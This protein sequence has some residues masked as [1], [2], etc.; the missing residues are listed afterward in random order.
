MVK[1]M[2]KKS[3]REMVKKSER[4]QKNCAKERASTASSAFKPYNYS[5]AHS[6]GEKKKSLRELPGK[7]YFLNWSFSLVPPIR[8]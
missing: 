8:C 3:E 6:S 1:E 2:V 7:V 5:R 4:S